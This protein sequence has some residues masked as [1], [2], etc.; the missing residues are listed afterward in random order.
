MSSLPGGNSVGRVLRMPCNSSTR[1]AVCSSS[2]LIDLGSASCKF[3][4]PS[5]RIADEMLRWGWFKGCVMVTM[6]LGVGGANPPWMPIKNGC[7]L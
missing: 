3:G 2:E 4:V 7:C 1:E 5:G 6:R